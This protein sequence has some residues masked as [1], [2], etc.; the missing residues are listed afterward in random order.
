MQ[1][2]LLFATLVAMRAKLMVYQVRQCGYFEFGANAATCCDLRKLLGDVHNWI[3]NVRPKIE[4]TRTFDASND[5]SYLP[6]YCFDVAQRENNDFLLT[7][8]NE[9]PSDDGTVGAIGRNERAGEADVHTA[10]LP[11]NSIVGYGTHFWFLPD[12]SRVVTV[13]FGSQPLNGHVGMNKYLQ[14]YLERFSPHVR[15]DPAHEDAD[16]LVRPIIGYAL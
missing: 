4:N 8:W 3:H 1:C 11:A 5:G 14:G 12:R 6:V 16:T 2:G 9:T 15:F 13:R 7:T 10:N